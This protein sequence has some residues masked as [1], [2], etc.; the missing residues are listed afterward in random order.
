M[1]AL[2]M[3]YIGDESGGNNLKATGVLQA[4]LKCDVSDSRM[5]WILKMKFV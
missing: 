5:L 1:N 2:S 3:I 4:S